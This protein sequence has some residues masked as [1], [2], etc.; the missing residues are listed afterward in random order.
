MIQGE[1]L[2][3]DCRPSIRAHLQLSC[4]S[5]LSVWGTGMSFSIQL[6]TEAETTL[7]I[8]NSMYDHKPTGRLYGNNLNLSGFQWT[9]ATCSHYNRPL[10]KNYLANSILWWSNNCINNFAANRSEQWQQ[11]KQ[12]VM[13][14]NSGSKK[15]KS[16]QGTVQH[17]ALI[18]AWTDT[19]SKDPILKTNNCFSFWEQKEKLI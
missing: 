3:P 12:K 8:G 15:K 7:P 1:T 17:M 14:D 13:E 5:C 11:G 18:I 10:K 2:S 16:Q 6:I 19:L 4:N 9:A